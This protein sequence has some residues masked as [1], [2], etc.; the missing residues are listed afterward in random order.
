MKETEFVTDRDLYTKVILGEVPYAEKF[1]WIATSGI[2]DMYVASG[3]RMVPFLQVLSDL[4]RSGVLVRLLYAA[5]SGLWFREDFDRYPDLI[6]GVEQMVCPR[7]HFKSVVV[8]G[9]FGYTGSANLTGAGLGAKGENRRNFE[10]GFVT[11]EPALVSRLMDA[12]DLIW[13]GRHCPDCQR[14]KYCTDYKNILRS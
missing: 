11:R 6:R 2:K 7:I 9:R 8:D 3:D 4:V 14:K 12:F 13:M 5:L 10:Q 1:V